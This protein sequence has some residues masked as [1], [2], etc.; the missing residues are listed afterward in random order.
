MAWIPPFEMQTFFVNVFAGSPDIFLGMALIV[1]IG[2]AAWFKMSTLTM[3]IMIGLFVFMFPLYIQSPFV[4]LFS[5]IAALIVGLSV[6][7]IA[8]RT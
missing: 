2:M 8:N 6:N 5:V 7:K 4:A 1:I 3:F